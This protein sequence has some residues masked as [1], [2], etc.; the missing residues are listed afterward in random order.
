MLDGNWTLN[1]V[2][3][4]KYYMHSN[5]FINIDPRMNECSMQYSR[6]TTISRIS[7]LADAFWNFR[8]TVERSRLQVLLLVLERRV[9]EDRRRVKR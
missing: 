1:G 7:Q 8:K 4:I 2:L 9:L 6:T 3:F 5:S